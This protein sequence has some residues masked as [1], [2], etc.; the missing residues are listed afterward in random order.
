M[1]G[2]FIHIIGR[3]EIKATIQSKLTF[4]KLA[5][6]CSSMV[7]LTHCN[8]GSGLKPTDIKR[9][10]GQETDDDEGIYEEEGNL[11]SDNLLS[12]Q[13]PPLV[14]A[15]VPAK[16]NAVFVKILDKIERDN[17]T[18]QRQGQ[19][20]IRFITSVIKFPKFRP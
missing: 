4:L 12:P 11:P 6:I 2:L 7:W 1:K 18:A 17:C 16:Q 3:L 13:S 20:T 14:D 8:R 5:L 19:P 10:A 9:P 15:L